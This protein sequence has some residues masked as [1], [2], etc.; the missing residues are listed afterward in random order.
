MNNKKGYL[1]SLDAFLAV[2]V[3]LS[4]LVIVYLSFSITSSTMPDEQLV[5]DALLS[6][7]NLR[8]FEVNQPELLELRLQKRITSSDVTL[9]EQIGFFYD[10]CKKNMPPVPTK[11]CATFDGLTFDVESK[12]NAAAMPLDYCG[13]AKKITENTLNTLIP[14]QFGHSF[15]INGV[16][17]S[18]KGNIPLRGTDISVARSYSFGSTNQGTTDLFWG[19]YPVEV[20]LWR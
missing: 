8:V 9:L 20:L 15:S 17:L 13:C 6:L 5:Q 12:C 2:T 10:E 11:T 14:K 4:S 16:T 3:V 18:C 7:E 19:P 1:F